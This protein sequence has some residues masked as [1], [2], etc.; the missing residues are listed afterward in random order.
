MS[1][2]AVDPAEFAFILLLNEPHIAYSALAAI[3]CCTGVD[4]C[5]VPRSLLLDKT[6]ARSFCLW[7]QPLYTVFRCMNIPILSSRAVLHPA[8]PCSLWQLQ[9]SFMWCSLK[10]FSWRITEANRH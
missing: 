8:S 9:L 2:R 3:P 7:V 4:S 5:A 1:L 6:Q 10:L